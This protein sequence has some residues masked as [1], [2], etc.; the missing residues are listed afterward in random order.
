MPKHESRLAQ[1]I[2]RIAKEP[3]FRLLARALL[4]M[5]TSSCSTRALWDLGARPAYLL[6]M[7]SAVEQAKKQRVA[8]MSVIEFGVAGGEGL[9]AMQTD[10]AA[11]EKESGIGIKVYGF[12][13]GS[14]GL[15]DFVGDYRDHPEE[16]QPGDFPMDI[17][18]LKGRLRD[19][20]TLVLGNVAQTASAF[21]DTYEAPPIGFISIDVDLYSSTAAALRILTSENSRMLWHTPMYFDD[22]DF[23][24]NHRFA[25]ELLAIHQFNEL[26]PNVKIDR[27]YGLTNGRPFPERPYLQKM[28]V[29][30]DLRATTNVRLERA[31]GTLPLA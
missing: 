8:E 29:A 28:Y 24:F 13:M 31:R 9:V 10:A 27:W 18:A 25:G 26:S 21:F 11:L 2:E 5:S 15:P 12:D 3:P 22:I 20:T 19:R 1:S 7:V 16:W 23:I 6:G 14:A 30:H 17:A 4:R